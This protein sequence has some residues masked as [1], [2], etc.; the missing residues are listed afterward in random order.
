MEI[1]L[2][3]LTHCYFS[4]FTPDFYISCATSASVEDA[5]LA[6]LGVCRMD[7]GTRAGVQWETWLERALPS[8]LPCF[9]N[10]RDNQSLSCLLC[11][12]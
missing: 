2:K 3:T 10:R 6:M 9:S 11:L 4:F 8:P 12:G 5:E 1:P 7:W